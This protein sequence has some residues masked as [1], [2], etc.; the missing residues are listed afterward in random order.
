MSDLPRRAV[1]RTAKLASLPIGFAGRTAL[2]M[3]KRT[4]GKPAEMVALEIQQRTAEQLFK[5]LGE[6][7]GGAMKVGQMLSIFEAALPPEIAG[8]YRATL[9]KLQDAAPP[10]PARTVHNVLAENLGADW[11]DQFA[12]F[13]D[14]PAAAASIGQVHKAVWKDGRAVAVK[15]QYPG[16][17]KALMG[18]FNQMARLSR[19][20]AALMPGL[21]IK[22][23]LAELKERVAEELDYT[24]EADSQRSFHQAYKDDPDFFVPEVI[25]QSGHVLVTEWIDDG[26]PLSK[27]ISSGT[28]E[29]RDRAGLLYCRFLFSGPARCGLLHA[30]PHPGNYLL[31][32]DGRLGVIDFGAVDRL[33]GGFHRRI[34]VLMRIGTLLDVDK[35]E[36]ELRAENFLREGVEV[37]PESL[38]AFIAPIAEPLIEDTFK[39]SRE[40]LRQEAARVTDLRP[41]NVV[42]QLNLPPSYVLIHRVVTA[43]TGVLC[44]LEAE[45][46]FRGEA[47]T[48]V[49]GFADDGEEAEEAAL[50][51]PGHA[52]GSTPA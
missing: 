21:E 37:D 35:I 31:L 27:I 41:T 42:R 51:D 12:E 8:P 24:I 29:Q 9:T 23:M 40:W 13:D 38:H 39:F 49:P 50:A 3:G 44:Q 34:G 36:Q 14:R 25:A 52:A 17:G 48:W 16:A 15:V 32:P 4:L 11:R 46:P 19:L 1:T 6:L 30:D 26:T 2:G 7:K 43:G 33:P 18:D 47:L 28:Q 45:G 10:L 20:F 5:V 22:E